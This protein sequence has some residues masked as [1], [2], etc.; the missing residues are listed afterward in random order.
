MLFV[1]GG[2]FFQL[3][4]SRFEGRPVDTVINALAA[5]GTIAAVVVSLV[6][7]RNSR[8]EVQAEALIK[9]QILAVRYIPLLDLTL[10]KIGHLAINFVYSYE[11][12]AQQDAAVLNIMSELD[13]FQ[14]SLKMIDAACLTPIGKGCA[15]NISQAVGEI[16]ALIVDV[17]HYR[18]IVGDIGIN[19][20]EC[21]HKDW[22]SRVTRINDLV[23]CAL[24]AMYEVKNNSVHGL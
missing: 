22:F 18:K 6:L 20:I 24:E 16:E 21:R 11:D 17:G 1:C 19:E 10:G 3:F 8:S 13:D 14:C 15:H 9:A 7:A 23:Q 12:S 5:I 4:P 2:L